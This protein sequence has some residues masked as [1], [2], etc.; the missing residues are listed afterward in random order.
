MRILPRMLGYSTILR[1]C[2]RPFQTDRRTV[3]SPSTI[4]N[5]ARNK[6]CAASLFPPNPTP[7]PKQFRS[8]GRSHPAIARPTSLG[9]AL[10]TQAQAVLW[11]KQNI[12]VGNAIGNR[13]QSG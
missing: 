6:P 1:I 10:Q 8:H 5:A 3:E 7:E 9:Y 11:S 12:P 2:G 13:P 4:D